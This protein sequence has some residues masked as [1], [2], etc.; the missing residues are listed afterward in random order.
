MCFVEQI[1]DMF[2]EGERIIIPMRE[3]IMSES[4]QGARK[5]ALKK[6]I[7]FQIADFESLFLLLKRR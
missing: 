3:M 6:L 1:A 5:R 4:Q 2:F 7:D